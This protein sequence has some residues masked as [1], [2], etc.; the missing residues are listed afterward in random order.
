VSRCIR[1]PAVFLL[2][3]SL[4]ASAAATKQASS[5]SSSTG[6]SAGTSGSAQ[7]SSTGQRIDV[8]RFDKALVAR[9]VFEKTNAERRRAGLQPFAW[10]DQLAVAATGHSEDM[11][12]KDYFSHDGKG[13]FNKS[14]MTDR[15]QSQGVQ[16][17]ATAENIA[18]LPVYRR[19]QTRTRY[20]A[21]GNASQTLE[22]EGDNYDQLTTWAVDQW[23]QSP[24]HRK[25]ILDPQLA[26]LGVGVALGN[27]GGTPYVY[28]TQDF[29]GQ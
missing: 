9:Q 26:R 16:G 10:L 27:H 29:A 22:T 5:K 7:Q 28:L 12:A 1:L 19:W 8:S 11:A 18:M 23:M 21:Q 15:L 24:G 14:H 20:D 2:T 4:G 17:V 25:N 13:W 6:K 3:I